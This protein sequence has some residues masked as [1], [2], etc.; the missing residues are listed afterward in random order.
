MA[1]DTTKVNSSY[2]FNGCI[3]FI[4]AG[5]MGTALIKS[6]LSIGIKANQICISEKVA[7]KSQELNRTLGISEKSIAEIASQCDLIFL[8]VKPQDLA[9]LLT[10]LSKSL[11][12]KT[13]LL[14]IA[15]GKTTAFIEAG[16]GKTNPV[17]RIMPNTPAQVGKGVSAISGG[18]YAKADD[19]A[20]A[21]NLLSASGLVVQVAEAQQDA[22]TALSGSGP[23]YFFYFVEEMIKSGVALG[24]SQEIATKL[25]IGTITGSAAMLQESGLDAATLRKNVTSPNGTTAAAI[26]E[27]EKA[28]LAQ[29]I[30][31]AMSAAKKR[32]QEL[33]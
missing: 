21:T 23:A 12:E 5:V 27:F 30:N 26:N 8:A 11:P 22:V 6:L 10:Q 13:L 15:A 3:G 16:I 25:A 14:S 4:G 1:T 9:D 24:L 29:I 31:D 28:N 19:L 20:M 32:A 18:K 33:A 17:I 7:E 2:S